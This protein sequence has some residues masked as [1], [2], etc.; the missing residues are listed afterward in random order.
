M[1][2]KRRTSLGRST[3]AARRMEAL[4]GAETPEEARSRVDDQRARQAA[5]R[6]AETPEQTRDRVGDQRAR[7]A[8]SRAVETS[9]EKK[10]GRVKIEQGVRSLEQLKRPNRDELAARI[11]VSDKQPHA[12]CIGCS[13]K[14]KL[15]N[16]TR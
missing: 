10:T 3:S 15:F 7:Q 2:P 9:E 16:T 4:R 13:W 5:S 14:E 12:H 8:A 11:N 1:P 6:A